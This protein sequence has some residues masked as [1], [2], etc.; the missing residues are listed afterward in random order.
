MQLLSRQLILAPTDLGNFLGCRQLVS[1]DRAAAHGET[2]RPVR[3]D[4][5][6]QE[7]RERG[8]H[9]E[10]AWLERR[11]QEGRSIAGDHDPGAEESSAGTGPD[12]TLA[13]MRAGTDVVYQATLRNDVW[14]GRADFL[15]RAPTPSS[16]ATRQTANTASLV[17]GLRPGSALARKPTDREMARV[18]KRSK[19]SECPRAEVHDATA[20]LPVPPS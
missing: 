1:L 17:A 5:H 16:H 11:R 4:P 13:A 20:A 2:A 19:T 18:D 7:L 15:L 8:L 9:H 3:H 14:S 10:R 6:M 12:E